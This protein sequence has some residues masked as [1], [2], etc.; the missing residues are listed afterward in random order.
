MSNDPSDIATFLEGHREEILEA[1][2]EKVA[3]SRLTHYDAVG[4]E[5]T[6]TRLRALLDT[7]VASARAHRLD[8]ATG[9]ASSLAAERQ[10]AGYDLNEV[11][12]A[13]NSVEE[14]AWK[15]ITSDLPAD[16]QANALGI[17]STIL[18]A[19]KDHLA[20]SYLLGVT[21]HSPR[22]LRVETLFEGT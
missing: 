5:A 18:G 22:T 15:A 20:C 13:I 4:P 3:R 2:G 7:V 19:I 11:Q 16:A 9:Y 10:G 6:A 8:P 1:A 14:A 17:V 21:G 12:T